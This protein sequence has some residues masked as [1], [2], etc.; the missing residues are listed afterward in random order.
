MTLTIYIIECKTTGFKYFNTTKSENANFNP[1]NWMISQNKKEGNYKLLAASVEEYG[2][3]N[4]SERIID[5]D[6]VDDKKQTIVYNKIKKLQEEG[7]SLNDILIPPTKVKC[8]GCGL[9]IR[10]YFLKKHILEYCRARKNAE[11]LADLIA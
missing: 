5:C 10:E 4:H 1:L 2:I 8:I 11:D 6:Y 9:N 7:T 3:K